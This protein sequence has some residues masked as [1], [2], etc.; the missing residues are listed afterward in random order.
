MEDDETITLTSNDSAKFERRQLQRQLLQLAK[1]DASA[2]NNQVD[3]S[4]QQTP[5]IIS[6]KDLDELDVG[7]FVKKVEAKKGNNQVGSMIN[8]NAAEYSL[9]DPSFNQYSNVVFNNNGD[10]RSAE[11]STQ[12][13]GQ[14]F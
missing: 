1:V 4:Q 2:E 14:N 11:I 10:Q 3:I 8:N 7:R 13:Q 12:L 5:P 6:N 9:M